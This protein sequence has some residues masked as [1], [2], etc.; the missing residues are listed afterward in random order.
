MEIEWNLS[1]HGRKYLKMAISYIVYD[2]VRI[3][4]FFRNEGTGFSWLINGLVKIEPSLLNRN[5]SK[6]DLILGCVAQFEF[7]IGLH[8][9]RVL[10][11][12]SFPFYTFLVNYLFYY[13]CLFKQN[14]FSVYLYQYLDAIYL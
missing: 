11:V 4:G 1:Y 10:V 12:L 3:E 2:L 6:Y 9:F 8:V 14:V 5:K 13:F 7:D